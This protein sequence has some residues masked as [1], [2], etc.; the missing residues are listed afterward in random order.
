[1]PSFPAP[2]F[3]TARSTLNR[4]EILA[5]LPANT[6]PPELLP[7]FIA[8]NDGPF[9][10][11]AADRVLSNTEFTRRHLGGRRGDWDFV[12]VVEDPHRLLSESFVF[13]QTSREKVTRDLETVAGLRRFLRDHDAPLHFALPKPMHISSAVNPAGE[14]AVIYMMRKAHGRELG[15]LVIDW[16]KGRSPNPQHHFRE[17]LHFLAYFHAWGYRGSAQ[18]TATRESL[19]DLFRKWLPAAAAKALAAELQEGFPLL[20]KKDAHPEN[21]LLS[22]AGEIVM[23]DFESSSSSPVGLDIAQLLDDYPLLSNDAD[24]WKIRLELLSEY[25]NL[26]AKFDIEWKPCNSEL[27]LWYRALVLTRCAFGLRRLRGLARRPSGSFS[28]SA[29]RAGEWRA[30]HYRELLRF[31]GNSTASAGIRSCAAKL[32]DTESEVSAH[33]QR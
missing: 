12:Y 7:A 23:L 13:K 28:S 24:G 16:R 33:R 27:S 26:L 25:S 6:L 17:A 2:D 29:L 15:Q 30:A 14:G 21:W 9:L 31:L 11:R 5:G 19:A 1:M 10:E 18:K 8:A 22:N 32:L 20:L 4:N 3:V